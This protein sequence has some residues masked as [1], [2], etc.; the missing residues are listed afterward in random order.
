MHLDTIAPC[1]YSLGMRLTINLDEDLYAIA[2]ALAKT[3]DVSVSTAVN[4]LIR[5]SLKEPSAPGR[6]AG[7]FPTVKCRIPVT[8]DDVARAEQEA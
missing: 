4:D 2:K 6:R 8:A 3:D 7:E 5:R 1:S